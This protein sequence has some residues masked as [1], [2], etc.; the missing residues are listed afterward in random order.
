MSF[1]PFLPVGATHSPND[2][3]PLITI[4][5]MKKLIIAAIIA[6]AALGYGMAAAA[7]HSLATVPAP[8]A[9]TAAE[10]GTPGEDPIRCS[11]EGA[12]VVSWLQAGEDKDNEGRGSGR[13]ARRD[14]PR[15]GSRECFPEDLVAP[16]ASVSRLVAL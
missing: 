11:R 16:S 5:T 2:N 8:P 10:C 3:Y 13:F 6:P 14:C 9:R 15:R 12:Q 1:S 4:A 7:I